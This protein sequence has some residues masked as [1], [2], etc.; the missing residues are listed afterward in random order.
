MVNGWRPVIGEMDPARLHGTGDSRSAASPVGH[1][2]WFSYQ[3]TSF[4]V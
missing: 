4:K 2:N 3:K 1:S